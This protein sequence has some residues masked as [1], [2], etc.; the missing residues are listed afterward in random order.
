VTLYVFSS[1]VTIES[2]YD[3]LTIS[4][5]VANTLLKL[6]ARNHDHKHRELSRPVH[7]DDIDRWVLT[8]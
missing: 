1:K 5:N 2:N 8:R 4:Y 3:F 7:R 6:L